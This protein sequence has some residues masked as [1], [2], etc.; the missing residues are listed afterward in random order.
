MPQQSSRFRPP[1]SGGGPNI[2]QDRGTD[3]R[4]MEYAERP[5]GWGGYE[6]NYDVAREAPRRIDAPAQAT[7][8]GR[9]PKNYRRTDERTRE[10]VCERLMEDS[11]ID[12]SEIEVHVQQGQI[13]LAGTVPNR[14]TKYAAED[15][16]EACTGAQITN[17]LRVVKRERDSPWSPSEWP[18]GS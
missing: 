13:T 15:L 5:H 12:A 2:E 11:R 16:I 9:G 4:A 3:N 10:I 1:H 14:W 18:I 17:E 8:R 6:A 7:Y